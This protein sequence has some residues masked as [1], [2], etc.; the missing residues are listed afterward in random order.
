MSI[1]PTVSLRAGSQEPRPATHPTYTSL[2]NPGNRTWNRYGPQSWW[3]PAGRAGPGPPLWLQSRTHVHVHVCVGACMYMGTCVHVCTRGRVTS[4]RR[5]VG[6]LE[7]RPPRC[8]SQVDSPQVSG[9]CD[10]VA[11]RAE[12]LGTQGPQPA[13]L[14]VHMPTLDGREGHRVRVHA[15]EAFVTV[16]PGQ[17]PLKFPDPSLQGLKR[18]HS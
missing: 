11:L 17:L 2:P 3:E 5:Q 18:G 16:P 1:C 13:L 9:R 8:S 14:A 10:G 7:A 15:D 12:L 4:Q 6:L